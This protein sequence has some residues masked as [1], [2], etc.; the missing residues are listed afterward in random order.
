MNNRL[1]LRES[2][3]KGAGVT[4][5]PTFI[6]GADI[7]A[8]RLKAVLTNT[9]ALQVSIYA[10]YPQRK[11]LSPKFRAFADFLS[12]QIRDAPCWEPRTRSG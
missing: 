12:E 1:A 3:L 10:V 8:G 5:M 9:K 6:V 11:H 2:L 7:Q 4:L